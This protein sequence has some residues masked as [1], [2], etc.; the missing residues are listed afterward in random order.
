M[1][2]KTNVKDKRVIKTERDIMNAFLE[3]KCN[4]AFES[5]SISEVCKVAGVSRAT[6]YNHFETMDDLLD[7]TI[8][9]I[10]AEIPSMEKSIN[11]FRWQMMKGGEPLCVYVRSRPLLHGLFY[12]TAMHA[13]IVEKRI[14]MNGEEC[15]Q[16]MSKFGDI[17]LDQYKDFMRFQMTGCLAAMTRMKDSSDSEWAKTREV[18]DDM[19]LIYLNNHTV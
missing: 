9:S 3:L 10:L 1:N 8:E 13:R 12:D 7:R 4:S 2:D 6:F 17:P 16:I 19:T 5:I 11:A 14:A 15:W 18:I